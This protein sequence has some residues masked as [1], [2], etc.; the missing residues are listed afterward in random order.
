MSELK[1]LQERGAPR[2]RSETLSFRTSPTTL[3]RVE[4]IAERLGRKRSVVADALL[5]VY[6]VR[7][8]GNFEAIN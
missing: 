5:G 8:N 3:E 2:T 7:R 1:K 4:R 6:V